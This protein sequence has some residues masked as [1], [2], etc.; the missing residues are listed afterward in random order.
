MLSRGRPI[1]DNASG[2]SRRQLLE[3]GVVGTAALGIPCSMPTAGHGFDRAAYNRYIGLMN[4]GD[5]RFLDNYADDVRFVMNMRGKTAVR[6]FYASQRP[7]V[8]EVLE[9]VF[10]CSDLHGAAAQVVSKIRCIA[11]CADTAIFGRALK[12]GDVQ[13]VKGCLL[14]VLNAQGRIAQIMGPPPE[15]LQPWKSTTG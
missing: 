13:T 4:A 5:L 6:D 9:V 7:F 15:I 12:A 11:D 8:H 1:L 2:V 3:T 14:Y 10:F